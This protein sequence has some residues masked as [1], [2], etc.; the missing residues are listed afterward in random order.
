MFLHPGRPLLSSVK[1]SYILLLIHVQ[2]S[3]DVETVYRNSSSRFCTWIDLFLPRP[4]QEETKKLRNRCGWSATE[5][6]SPVDTS[7]LLIIPVVL[8]VA[9]GMLCR[10]GSGKQCSSDCTGNP[11]CPAGSCASSHVLEKTWSKRYGSQAIQACI[12]NLKSYA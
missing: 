10:T 1:R 5:F 7:K 6:L 4:I 11:C 3:W 9:F 12:I 8:T 2:G